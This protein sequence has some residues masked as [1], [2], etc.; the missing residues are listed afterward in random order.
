MIQPSAM[1]IRKEA[2]R[3]LYF[4]FGGLFVMLLLVVLAGLLTGQARQE[5]EVAKAQAE[6][7]GVA[8]P[9][10]TAAVV[11]TTP[12]TEPL[13]DITA[14]PGAG[15]VAPTA[16]EGVVVPDLQPDPKLSQPAR[17]P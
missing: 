7:A 6:A 17:Q 12:A 1:E 15:P 5:A 13:G 2:R 10:G 14:D 16:E 4:G 11:P 8:N 9:G 3:R